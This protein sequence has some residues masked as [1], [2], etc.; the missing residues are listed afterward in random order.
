MYAPLPADRITP[1][2]PFT[3][4]G[5]DFTGP[6]YIPYDG[7]I[8][9]MYIC[10][11]TCAVIRAVHL[12]LVWDLTTEAFIRSF[13]R[14]IS[15]RGFPNTIYTDNA[16]T[17]K[18]GQKEIYKALNLFQSKKFKEFLGDQN[19]E[20]KFIV[21]KA[22]WWGGFYES[23]MSS[24]KTPL[25]KILKNSTLDV[26]EMNTVIKE[27][28]AMVN[29]RPLTCVYDDESDLSYLTPAK[30]ILGRQTV[31]LQTEDKEIKT[32]DG[33]ELRKRRKI[34]NSY[35]T[36]IWKEWREKYLNQLSV[37]NP[38]KAITPL[39]IGQLVQVL[40]HSIPKQ[41]WK[42]G[43]IETLHRGKDGI[44]RA[45][46]VK[47]ANNKFLERHIRHVSVL[48]V[49]KY[50]DVS[51]SEQIKKCFKILIDCS[52]NIDRSNFDEVDI[53]SILKVN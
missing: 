21:P 18:K 46:K 41:I 38:R 16:L 36:Q 45:V 50:Y 32:S 1:Q 26:D 33:N 8:R 10:L 35:L 6:L 37:N 24:I 17:F 40:D 14:F 49:D 5:I 34:Q 27:V 13:R 52:L 25:K 39:T 15:D 51:E 42:V 2:P 22:P 4:V 3:V 47:L 7:E 12:E 23:L 20:W 44:I 9:K 30:F 19:I 53:E 43:L 29:S 48:E 11:F 31:H 28:A